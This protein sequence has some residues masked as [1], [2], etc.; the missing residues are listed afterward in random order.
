MQDEPIIVTG[1]GGLIGRAVSARLKTAGL[2]CVGIDL[3]ADEADLRM[4]IR[5]TE[6]LAP[7][8]EN[9]AGIVH[10]AAVSRVA[11]GERDPARCAAVNVAATQGLLRAALAA[12]RRP[13]VLFASSREVYGEPDR[14]P[15]AEDAPCRPIG[16]YARSKV[17]AEIEV[18]RAREAGLGTATIRLANV[19]GSARDYPDRVV[20]AFATAASRGGAMRVD[21]PDC[22]LDLTHLD[23]VA[24]GIARVCEALRQGERNLPTV[25]FVS[26]RRIALR[27]LALMAN[28]LG[29]GKSRIVEAPPR[30]FGARDFVGDPERARALLG[31]TATT[32]LRNGL[33]RLIAELA[34]RDG[35]RRAATPS[36]AA[37]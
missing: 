30:P 15:V 36:T 27:E 32:P 16:A 18:G 9:A 2:A 14:L 3:L 21:G 19:Y 28:E 11:D 29:G 34:D 26:G 33:T 31:W 4:D 37:G 20:P 7:F 12:G 22:G 24:E 1:S 8:V 35:A 5:E 10:L 13:W 23:D 17:A 6:R 25:H